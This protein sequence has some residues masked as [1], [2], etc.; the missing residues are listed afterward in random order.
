L[1]DLVFETERL[2][3]RHWRDADLPGIEAVYGNAEAMRWVGDGQPISKA[4]CI[5]WLE[6]TRANYQQRGY[7]MF[8]VELRVA[9]GLIG[10][11]GIVHPGG[12]EEPEIKYAYLPAYWGMG[13]ATEAARGMLEYAVSQHKLDYL[14]ATT[15]PENTASHRVLLKAGMHYGELKTDADGLQTQVFEYL[16]K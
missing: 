14:I 2:L 5:Q 12:Q 11:C 9:P 3:V 8:A 10:C 6:V 4:Q 7:G 1:K 15:A 13:I 16:A